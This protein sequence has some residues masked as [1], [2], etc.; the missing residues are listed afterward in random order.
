[1]NNII[2]FLGEY[3]GYIMIGGLLVFFWQTRKK[4]PRLLL[5]MIAGAVLS[6][7]IITELVRFFWE[8]P[9]PFIEN[10]VAPLIE[11]AASPSFPSGHA[12]FFF[13][14]SAVLYF[15]NKKA[16]ILFLLGSALLSSARVFAGLHWTSDVIAGAVIGIVSGVLVVQISRRFFK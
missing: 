11:H 15:Y 9:R 5:E 16:G 2:V 13:A 12:T 14:I 4:Y 10:N 7:G 1:M 3:L 8:R 6:R